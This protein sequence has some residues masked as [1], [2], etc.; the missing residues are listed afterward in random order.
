MD[1]IKWDIEFRKSDCED[2][3]N[4]VADKLVKQGFP[5]NEAKEILES[6]YG[7]VGGEY[8]D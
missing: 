3:F 6:L 4:K 1:K 2:E 5:R 8:G 7:T